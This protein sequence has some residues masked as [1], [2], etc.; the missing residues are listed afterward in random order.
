MKLINQKRQII[1]KCL[2]Y[3]LLFFQNN[4]QLR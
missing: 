1:K 2:D 4:F 3:I